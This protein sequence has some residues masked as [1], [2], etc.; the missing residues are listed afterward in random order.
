MS[1][2]TAIDRLVSKIN[3]KYEVMRE[4]WW[5]MTADELIA[6]AEK[7]AAAKFVKEN[8]ESCVSEDEAGYFLSLKDPLEALIDSVM[9]RYDPQN[10]AEL[11]WFSN[12]LYDLCDKR[13]LDVDQEPEEAEGL[14]MI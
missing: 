2:N 10:Y 9:Y 4:G 8:I 1:D 14:K 3:K 5:D 6:I 7:I 11:E 13:D 12:C